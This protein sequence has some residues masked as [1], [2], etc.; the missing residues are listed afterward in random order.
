M[1]IWPGPSILV[2]A[3]VFGVYLVGSGVAALILGLSLHVST[4]HRVLLFIAGGLS[5][6]LGVLAFR[7]LGQGYA[8]LLLALWI[9]I[10]FIFHGVATALT[11]VSHPGFPGRGWNIFFGSICVVTGIVV[12]AS[13]FRSLVALAVVTGVWLV[14]IG[15]AQIATALVMHSDMKKASPAPVR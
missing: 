4:A 7:H 1:L 15:I 13:P 3:V 12:I 5:L 9:G 6:I 2:A 8:A 11:A 14:A 10:G